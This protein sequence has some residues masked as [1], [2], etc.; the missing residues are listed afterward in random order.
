MALPQASRNS[1]LFAALQTFSPRS[2]ISALDSAV[3]A[4]WL[5][6]AL[7]I[8]YSGLTLRY[9]VIAAM[10]ICMLFL[11]SSTRTSRK[12]RHKVPPARVIR[13]ARMSITASSSTSVKPARRLRLRAVLGDGRKRDVVVSC[14]IAGLWVRGY[15][16]YRTLSSLVSISPSGPPEVSP[17]APASPP[18]GE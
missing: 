1:S 8:G 13:I 14:V 7:A 5:T 16:L 4:N 6:Q 9:S 10:M 2:P 11:V 12:I 3:A 15:L 17:G 18:L